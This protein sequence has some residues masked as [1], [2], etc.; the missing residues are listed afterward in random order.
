MVFGVVIS[1]S[2]FFYWQINMEVEL[3][4]EKIPNLIEF[5][6]HL[7]QTMHASVPGS[8]VIWSVLQYSVVS[9]T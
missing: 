4:I 7:T 3:D 2:L 5:V 8:L 6:S 9:I 1:N